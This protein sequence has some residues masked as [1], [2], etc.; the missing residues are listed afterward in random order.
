MVMPTLSVEDINKQIT[1]LKSV[2]AWLTLNMNM[3]RGTIQ[4]LEVQSATIATLQS[5]GETVSAMV[6]PGNAAAGKSGASAGPSAGATPNGDA[7][8]TTASDARSFA[9]QSGSQSPFSFTPP[10]AEKPPAPHQESEPQAGETGAQPAA[11]TPIGLTAP[12]TNPAIWWNLLQDQFKQAVNTAVA[13]GAEPEAGT[14]E[15]KPKNRSA[16]RPAPAAKAASRAKAGAKS[17]SRS[18]DGS[19]KGSTAAK[20]KTAAKS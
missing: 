11:A 5:M 4:A 7:S 20:R 2:E 12:F 8:R 3:L 6:K 1:D 18:G 10:T 17:S 16:S 19:R 9:A 15:A 14:E 13:A